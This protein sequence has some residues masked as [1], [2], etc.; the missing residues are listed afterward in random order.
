MRLVDIP[1]PDVAPATP[2]V[3][4]AV[5]AAGVTFPEVLQTRGR[6]QVQPDL[7]F[8]PGGEIAGV[9]DRA[10]QGGELRVGDRV[11]GH[12]GTGGFA[13]RVWLPLDRAFRLAD[14]VSFVEGAALFANFHTAWFAL[15]ERGRAVAGESVL[16]HGA[17]G[18][19]G[20]ACIQVAQALGLTVVAVVSGDDKASAARAAG[21][22]HV[23][24]RDGDWRVQAQALIPG[25]VDLVIDP[26]GGEVIDNL[27]VL[28]ELGRL[29]VVGFAGGELPSIPAN[30][31]LLRN[32]EAIGIVYG[33]F[34]SAHAGYS[35]MIQSKLDPLLLAGLRPIIGSTYPLAVAGLALARVDERRAVGKVVL[36]LTA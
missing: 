19:L 31:L 24:A 21:A 6:Y 11:F 32:L 30:R 25:G 9:V 16:V 2:S 3:R 8:V 17:G 5:M 10:P 20:T 12:C 14:D 34:A 1:E 28:R 18:G 22:H 13:E 7:P 4:V 26:V 27:R 23:L 29:L 36:D 35:R 15:V 33:S